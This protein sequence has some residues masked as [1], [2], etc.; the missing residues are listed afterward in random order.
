MQ[1]NPSAL[2]HEKHHSFASLTDAFSHFAAAFLV[3]VISDYALAFLLCFWCFG[4]GNFEFLPCFSRSLLPPP[5]RPS[6]PHAA[7]RR[8]AVLSFSLQ[9]SLVKGSKFDQDDK[10]DKYRFLVDLVTGKA[11][12]QAR[13]RQQRRCGETLRPCGMTKQTRSSLSSTNKS[14]AHALLFHGRK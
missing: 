5:L 13:E 9:A 6:Q 3:F 7:Q 12:G 2:K 14:V 8:V 1:K 4:L 11:C 10:H